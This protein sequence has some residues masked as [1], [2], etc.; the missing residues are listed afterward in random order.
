[1]QKP[2]K[3][4]YMILKMNSLE[5]PG[6]IEKLKEA[7]QAGVKI[8]M[9]VR[10]ICC[11]VPGIPG[12][13][14]NIEII[15]I[16]DRFLEHARVYIFGNGDDEELIFTASA[17]WMTR[18]L[19]NRIEV[20]IPIYSKEIRQQIR[21]IIDLQLADN[22]KAR[23]IDEKQTNQFRDQGSKQDVLRAQIA[24]YRY[25]ESMLEKVAQ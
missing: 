13:S 22:Q 16:V 18:N 8:Q 5:E 12:E 3:P 21:H 25:L 15:S 19:F 23:V 4:A 6:M 11:L 1:M 20:G 17:D 24:T 10:G 9:I 14:D 2:G 7:S